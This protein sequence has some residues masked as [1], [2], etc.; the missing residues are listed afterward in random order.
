M[1]VH[2]HGEVQTFTRR[3]ARHVERT[4]LNAHK[5]QRRCHRSTKDDAWPASR[6]QERESGLEQRGIGEDVKRP[7]RTR[8]WKQERGDN[9]HAGPSRDCMDRCAN[10]ERAHALA[11]CSPN[12]AVD[13]DRIRRPNAERGS[14]DHHQANDQADELG[15]RERRA[16]PNPANDA[17]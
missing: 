3:Q 1:P 14:T 11:A 16:S 15:L 4:R 17:K 10:C 8:R 9:R 2:W 12:H 7:E 6:E 13:G 5:E